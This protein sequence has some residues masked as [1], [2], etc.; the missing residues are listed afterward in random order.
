VV[1]A[2]DHQVTRLTTD[3]GVLL[4]GA[5]SGYLAVLNQLGGRQLATAPFAVDA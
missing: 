2:T 4:D 3:R 1:P 5:R